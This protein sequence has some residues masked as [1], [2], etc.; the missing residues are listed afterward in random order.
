MLHV[1]HYTLHYTIEELN[2]K[3]MDERKKH[4]IK[5]LNMPANTQK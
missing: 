1:T 5:S 2:D 3:W 4:N